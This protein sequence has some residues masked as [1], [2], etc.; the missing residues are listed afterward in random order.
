MRAGR[1]VNTKLED[2]AEKLNELKVDFQNKESEAKNHEKKLKDIQMSIEAMKTEYEEAKGDLTAIQ[3]EF[4][5]LL[6]N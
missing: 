1:D 4:L 3:V 6:E 2:F 5:R